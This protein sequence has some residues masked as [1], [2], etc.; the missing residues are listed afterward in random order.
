DSEGRAV[1]HRDRIGLF[2]LFGRAPFIEAV[3]REDASAPLV[4]VPEGRQTGDCLGLRVDRLAAE[5]RI[6]APMRNQAPPQ[7]I[8]RTL[9]GL[10]VLADD[11]QF[12]ARRAVPSPRVV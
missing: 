3:D 6:F 5:G 9:A 12:L 1:L 7:E 8:E 11:Q 2:A 4:R 10:A